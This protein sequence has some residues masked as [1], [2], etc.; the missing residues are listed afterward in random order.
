MVL[1]VNRHFP[2][3]RAS[4]RG[5]YHHETAETS[6]RTNATISQRRRRFFG[7]GVLGSIG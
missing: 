3:N 5:Q 7:G 2:T 6:T 1:P 4:P